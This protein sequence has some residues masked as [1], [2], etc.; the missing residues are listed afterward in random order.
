MLFFSCLDMRV[1][2]VWDSGDGAGG[3]E[4]GEIGLSMRNVSAVES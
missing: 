1:R 3:S 4:E 2:G